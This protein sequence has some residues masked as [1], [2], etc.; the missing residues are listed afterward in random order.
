M[1]ITVAI[2]CIKT[3]LM[4][5]PLIIYVIAVSVLCTVLFKFIQ[6]CYFTTSI[7]NTF[8][9]TSSDISKTA[10]MNPFQAFMNSLNS[11]LGNGSIGGV[12]VA[13]AVGGPGAA[14]WMVIV[15]ILLMAVRFAEI[16]LTMYFGRKKLG[17]IF[18][19][20]PMVY[21]DHSIG[22]KYLAYTY[23]FLC[24]LFGF[25]G[26][27]AIQTNTIG[28]SLSTTWGIPPLVNACMVTLFVAYIIFGGA[29][30]IIQVSVR[31]VPIKVVV[32]FTSTIIILGYHYHALLPA[33][34]LIITSAFNPVALLGGALGFT[35]QQALSAGINAIVF[36]SEAGL[37]TAAIVYGGSESKNPVV[38]SISAMFGVF[39]S[40]CVCFMVALCIVVTGVWNSG[41]T[42]TAL[43][44]AAFNSTFGYAGGLIVSFLSITFGMG[45]LVTYAYIAR[46]V[47]LYVT[48]GKW[49]NCFIALYCI[50]AFVGA[51]VKVEMLWQLADIMNA[52]ILLL[53]LFG[54][55][56]L[57]PLIMRGLSRYKS[58]HIA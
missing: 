54:I 19:G 22:G 25:I 15:G 4:G 39:I 47:W 32:F 2:D 37:G 6:F 48:F 17:T 36:A 21:L 56:C 45:V 23:A 9:P 38:D 14:F 44:V 12:A 57:L 33:L 34:N 27:N 20:G 3:L 1:N 41:L 28:L 13:V 42:S 58:E 5:W 50:F 18:L 29:A 26:G 11:G 53:N 35:I 7:K 31:I 52:V 46:S 16:Y 24:L 51:L 30:R 40:T 10:D 49:Q 43:T 8:A 55:I